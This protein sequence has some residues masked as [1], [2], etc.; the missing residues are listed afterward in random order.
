MRSQRLQ[1]AD[2]VVPAIR[3]CT[4]TNSWNSNIRMVS[5]TIQPLSIPL[6][7][8]TMVRKRGFRGKARMNGVEP[9]RLNSQC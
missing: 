1:G 2:V 3:V 6:L 9:P 8:E 7:G 4:D 5:I